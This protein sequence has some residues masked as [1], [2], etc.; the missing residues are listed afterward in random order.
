MAIAPY[1]SGSSINPE[2]SALRDALSL[3][4]VVNWLA[5]SSNNNNDSIVDSQE[6]CTSI[7][8]LTVNGSTKVGPLLTMPQEACSAVDVLGKH[9]VPQ[10]P[11]P[12][13]NDVSDLN[14]Y[15]ARPAL[16]ARGVFSSTTLNTAAVGITMN[17][18]YTYFPQLL[19]RTSGAFGMSFDLNFTITVSATPFAQGVLYGSFQY[20]QSSLDNPDTYLRGRHRWSAGQLPCVELDI[21]AATTAKLHIPFLHSLNF[22]PRNSG[23]TEAQRRGDL[24]YGLFTLTP[25]IPVSV[26]ATAQFP[27][28]QVMLHLTNVRFFHPS[29]LSLLHGQGGQILKGQ[30]DE[31]QRAAGPYSGLAYLAAGGLRFVARNVPSLSS[32]ATPAAWFL[33]ATGGALSAFGFSRPLVTEVP[34]RIAQQAPHLFEF[35]TD[36]PSNS[37]CLSLFASNN[38]PTDPAFAST[39]V[40]EMAIAGICSRYSIITA[41]TLRPSDPVGTRIF[42][43]PIRLPCLWFQEPPGGPLSYRQS[44]APTT[45]V[46]NSNLATSFYPSNVMFVGTM[47]SYWR[48]SF[49]IRLHFG[50][51]KMHAGRLVAAFTPTLPDNSNFGAP[52]DNAAA[53]DINSAI[54]GLSM[55]IDLKDDNVFEFDVPWTNP[56]DYA[57][58]SDVV[59]TFALW[60]L[61]P[62]LCPSMVAQYVDYTVEI[63][64]EDIEFARP[65]GPL[66]T[67]GVNS[68]GIILSNQSGQVLSN[69]CER[70]MG[71]AVQSLKSL[72]MLPNNVVY[73][74]NPQILTV[75]VMPWY[76]T[77]NQPVYAPTT[78]VVSANSIGFSFGSLIA[79]AYCW[80]KGSTEVHL[81]SVVPDLSITSQPNRKQVSTG[82][83][84]AT[85]ENVNT[86]NAPQFSASQPYDNIHARVPSHQ[87]VQRVPSFCMNRYN[88]SL[89]NPTLARI[90]P[91]FRHYVVPWFWS[92]STATLRIRPSSESRIYAYSAGDDAACG[93]YMGPPPLYMIK[94]N[95]LAPF[96]EAY[97]NAWGPTMV[98][99]LTIPPSNPIAPTAPAAAAVVSM[100]EF[101]PIQKAAQST[102]SILDRLTPTPPA[103]E[104]VLSRTLS[105]AEM[106]EIAPHLDAIKVSV[107]EIKS[108]VANKQ[109][110]QKQ[111]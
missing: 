25:K 95:S 33:R 47:F 51:T 106:Q 37:A 72:I 97:N 24:P 104:P 82:G 109:L 71:E 39:D 23:I 91:L 85:C 75:D 53:S 11:I 27:S 62:L 83:V 35:N 42:L 6:A 54:T 74:P 86:C 52:A 105:F 90:V 28:Y 92:V 21:S 55:I 59:G 78:V 87:I 111:K 57:C 41:L 38:I 89:N 10:R 29:P 98:P 34:Q 66:Y 32:I 80:V 7:D 18:L 13:P 2:K 68:G 110:I 36:V 61:D 49:K 12:T 79:S 20:Q 67:A 30:Q 93:H 14:A 26:A 76:Y 88:W 50:K 101:T 84:L 19:T 96:N 58:Y 64:S 56:A 9:Y 31:I 3:S 94:A 5:D 65:S 63:K 107:D 45:F 16:V 108:S 48:G 70:T 99:S 15:L 46:G 1:Y 8:G 100:V 60:I 77:P 17:Q 44:R 103:A 81:Y 4:P 22:L 73:P 102:G 40:D 69:V 43:L